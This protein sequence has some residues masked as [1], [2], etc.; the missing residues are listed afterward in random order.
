[1]ARDFSCQ[2]DRNAAGAVEQGERQTRRKLAGLGF[3]AVVVGDEI[4]R[5]LVEF[6]HQQAGDFGQTCLGVAHCGCAV[7][8]ARAKVALTVNQWV[9]LREILRHAHHGVVRGRVAVRVVFAQNIAHHAGRF[10]GF[11]AYR[12]ICTAIA[13]PHTRHA[14]QNTPLH[15]LLTIADIWQGAP[16]DDAERVFKVST[17]GVIGEVQIGI[18]IFRWKVKKGWVCHEN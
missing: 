6:V 5:A 15:R 14:V 8:I 2:T 9:A 16:L 4:N 13:Q 11:C 1:M 12:A 3:A 7:A 10:D 18:Y 17:L